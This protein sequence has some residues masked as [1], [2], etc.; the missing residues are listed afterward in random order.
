V[1]FLKRSKKLIIPNKYIKPSESI[2][3]LSTIII[4][5]IGN[6]KYNVVD[7]WLEIKANNNI[8]YNK[9]LQILIYLNI[10]GAIN[11]NKKGEIYNENIR[12]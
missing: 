12:S 4:K 3:Y 1:I 5:Q 8:T 9:Y 6:K 7:L 2:M 10:I 11:Y